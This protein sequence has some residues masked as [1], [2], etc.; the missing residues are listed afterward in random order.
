MAEDLVQIQK[1]LLC[2]LTFIS[3]YFLVKRII[4]KESKS[5]F[6]WQFPMLLALL[7]DVFLQ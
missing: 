1:I 6:E 5:Y 4:Y 3:G 2:I 7:I